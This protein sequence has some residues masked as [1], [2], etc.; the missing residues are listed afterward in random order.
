MQ[1][2]SE[3][4]VLSFVSDEFGDATKVKLVNIG[5]GGDNNKKGSDFENFYAAAKICM[6]AAEAKAASNDFRVS[7]QEVAFVDDVCVR[8][9]STAMK[10]NYQ[11]KN[12]SGAPADWDE[13][14]RCRFEMQQVID[15]RLHGA[16]QANQ[17]LLVSDAA[18]AAANDGKIPAAMKS[19]CQSEHFPHCTSSLRLVAAHP[20]LREALATLCGNNRLS[21]VDTAFRVVLGE[22]C[23]DNLNGRV[24]GDV[25]A[26]AKA[27]SKP[28]I[29][30]GVED[31][32][33]SGTEG[34][35]V[36]SDV[37]REVPKWLADLLRAFQF[38]PATVESGA[39]VTR[40]N[41]M[42]AMIDVDTAE[43]E[44]S[45]IAALQSPGD[46]FDFLMS[47]RAVQLAEDLPTGDDQQ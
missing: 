46:I 12:S 4:D 27:V 23:A 24:V 6:L 26:R 14:M 11:A 42:I 47:L 9:L 25:I 40:R 35:P 32:T 7:C 30:A 36:S 33:T 2:K 3:A 28:D 22:W 1:G 31:E 8:K 20:P 44:P 43:P 45:I 18:K 15:L 16:A 19:Y 38:E 13:D 39:F 34:D 37:S 41:G 10:T 21:S 17:I 29:F 5:R